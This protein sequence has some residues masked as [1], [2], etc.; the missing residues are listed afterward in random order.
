M[1]AMLRLKSVNISEHGNQEYFGQKL[2]RWSTH[3]A[4]AGGVM[5]AM[6]RLKSVTIS[7]HGYQ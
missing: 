4:L 6:L 3:V 1:V 7:D 2:V 5:V